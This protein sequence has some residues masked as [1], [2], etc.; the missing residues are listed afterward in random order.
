LAK[1]QTLALIGSETLMGRE[2]RDL[3]AGSTLGR[4]LRLIAAESEEP[5]KLTVH[6]GEPAILSTLESQNLENAHVIFLAGAVDSVEKLRALAPRARLIDLTYA[7]ED[8]PDARLRAPMVERAG[9]QAPPD[10]V[11][12]IAS[13]AAI[14]ITLVLGRLHP[15]HRVRRALAHIF[16]P[17]SE[18]GAVG[19]DELQ[20][21]TVG[22]LSFKG[23]PKAVF[24]AQL[25]FNMLSRYG[26]EAP[27][28]LEDAELRIERHLAT[29]LAALDGA[30]I[31]SLRLIQAPVFHG[32]SISLWTEFESSPGVSA[33]EQA[34]EG[35]PV[36]LRGAGL[37]PPNAVGIAG[38]GGLAIGNITLDRNNSQAVWLWVVADNLRLRAENA[39]A[40]AQQ[41]L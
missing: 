7:A 18:R 24:D 13:A 10:A 22:L 26:E 8:F 28:A 6:A 16:E 19:L 27:A 23:Q 12:V 11:H 31:P 15:A 3:L 36:D 37:E 14:A 25:A 2:V 5:G 21:Q 4:D 41:L 32:Y 34:L 20:Q 1:T 17:A 33:I 39:I 40:V 29:L 30:P 35:E 38:Q 9:Y